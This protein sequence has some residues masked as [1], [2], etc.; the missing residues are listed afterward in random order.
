ML[1]SVAVVSVGLVTGHRVL[2]DRGDSMRP[3]LR[4]GD[5]LISSSVAPESVAV[6]EI[7]TFEDPSAGRSITHRVVARRRVGSRV[8]FVTRGDANSGAERWSARTGDRLGR[9]VTSIPRAGYALGFL[10]SPLVRVGLTAVCVLV[11]CGLA[12]RWIWRED[13]PTDPP[14]Q[15]AAPNGR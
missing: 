4:S 8:D 14:A 13:Q 1:L 12:L 7:V 11:L 3:A 15:A 5:L 9:L 10:V 6:G 2:I